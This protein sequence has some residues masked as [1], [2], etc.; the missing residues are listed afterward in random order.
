M[1]RYIVT[2][3][4]GPYV[5]GLRNP[6]AGI[7]LYLTERQA[8]HDLRL[9][10][11]ASRMDEASRAAIQPLHGEDAMPVHGVTERADAD[12]SPETSGALGNRRTRRRDV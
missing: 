2:K 8:A 6:G 10:S 1:P 11:L 9:G 4:A 7:V 12:P 3:S 5:A